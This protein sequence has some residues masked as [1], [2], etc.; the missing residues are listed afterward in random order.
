MSHPPHTS[1]RDRKR[2]VLDATVSFATMVVML[3][4]GISSGQMVFV[5]LAGAMA[6]IG[7]GEASRSRFPRPAFVLLRT[8][9]MGMMVVLVYVVLA[10]FFGA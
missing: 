10:L 4:I 6:L 9:R 1:T 7:G 2:D 3:L 8:G 5:F